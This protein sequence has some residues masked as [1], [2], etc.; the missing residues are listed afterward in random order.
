MYAREGS[1]ERKML[2]IEL[3]EVPYRVLDVYCRERPASAL[4]KLLPRSLQHRT[5][6][7]DRLALDPWISWPSLHRGVTDETHQILHLGQ[8][9]DDVDERY[10]PIWRLLKERGLKVGVFGSLHSSNVPADVSDYSFYLPDYFGSELFAHPSSLAP[11]Q[12]LNLAMTRQSARN[13]TRKVPL[14]TFARFLANAPNSGLTL[15][16]ALDSAA[17]LVRETVDRSVRIRRRAYQ[18]LIMA[19]LFLRQLER[20][21]PDFATFYTN[22]VAAAMHRYWGAA[23]PED[24]ERPLDAEWIGRYEGEI[25]F[26][27]DKFDKILGQLVRF[28]DTHPE[29]TLLVASSMGQAA[30]PAEKTSEFLTITDLSKFMTQL[31]V[32]AGAWQARPA[33]IPCHCAVVDEQYRDQV[34]STASELIVGDAR[35]KLD[36]RP[37]APLSYDERSRGFFQ[38]FIQFDNYRGPPHARLGGKQLQLGELGLGLMAHEDDVNCTAQHVPEGSLFAYGKGIRED[39]GG[40]RGSLSTL[41]V[42]PSILSFFGFET[43]SHMRGAPTAFAPSRVLAS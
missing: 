19:D 6:T 16:T 2:L 27:M 5:T 41:D 24:Y 20:T 7:E 1:L 21:R 28:V 4:A 39:G 33:M 3:N 13:V 30:I 40:P 43:P 31:G 17:Q 11:F 22:H 37:V 35:M 9:I 23:F 10:P 26:A 32:P 36:K 8:P 14:G 29:Y 12:A 38:F 25:R 18:P 15:S 42:A 34:V